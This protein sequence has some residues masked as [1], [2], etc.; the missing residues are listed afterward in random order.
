VPTS[1]GTSTTFTSDATHH[2][3]SD[4]APAPF[5]AAFGHGIN[6]VHDRAPTADHARVS[7]VCHAPLEDQLVT[8][9]IATPIASSYSP[10]R[11][12]AS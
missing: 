3:A 12:A 7:T 5:F 9:P 8:S 10:T 1:D 2:G 11:W 6:A 4:H